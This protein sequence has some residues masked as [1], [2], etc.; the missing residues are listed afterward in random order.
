M[1]EGVPP[2]QFPTSLPC[3]NVTER[4]VSYTFPHIYTKKLHPCTVYLTHETDAAVWAQQ[5]IHQ[6]CRGN[7]CCGLCHIECILYRTMK[8]LGDRNIELNITQAKQMNSKYM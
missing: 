3:A 1:F 6:R 4:I 8:L 2:P 5:H 7:H